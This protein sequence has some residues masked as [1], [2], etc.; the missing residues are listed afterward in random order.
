MGRRTNNDYKGKKKKEVEDEEEER[1]K[2]M[3][4]KK[5]DETEEEEGKQ[6]EEN[7]INKKESKEKKEKD[8]KQKEIN[9]E[10]ILK[11]HNSMILFRQQRCSAFLMLLPNVYEKSDIMFFAIDYTPEGDNCARHYVFGIAQNFE[12]L[13]IRERIATFQTT[14]SITST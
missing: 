8:D 10:E 2:D 6:E 11:I 12:K 7:N 3:K 4:Q 9:I 13:E 1:Q 14:A 5:K